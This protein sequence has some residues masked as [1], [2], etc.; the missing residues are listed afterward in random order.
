M[1]PCTSRDPPEPGADGPSSSSGEA[2]GADATSADGASF[3]ATSF[4]E[5]YERYFEFVWRSLR[6][7]GVAREALDD[8][9]QDTFGVI[10]RQLPHFEGRSSLRTWV[11]GVAQRVAANHRRGHRRKTAALEPLD[12]HRLASAEPDAHAHAELREAV[13]AVVSF[14]STLDPGRRAVFVLGI[15]ENVPAVEIAALL[16]IPVNTVYTRARALRLALREQLQ[17]REVEH[18]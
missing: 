11:F 4:E 15:V 6:M 5:L 1:N 16:G 18:D 8:A 10:V 7:L 9:V 12:D 2:E 17:Q 14:C 3:E 13:D